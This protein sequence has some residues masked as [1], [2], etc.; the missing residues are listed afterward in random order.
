MTT[1]FKKL[2][3][4]TAV[5]LI[6]TRTNLSGAASKKLRT[7]RPSEGETQETLRLREMATKSLFLRQKTLLQ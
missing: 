2:F 3:H 6:C 1:L 4:N 7:S 5:D